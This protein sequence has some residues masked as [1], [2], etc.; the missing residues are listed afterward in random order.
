M[1]RDYKIVGS[2]KFRIIDTYLFKKQNVRVIDDMDKEC[3][4]LIHKSSWEMI[5]KKRDGV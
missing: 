3:F 4:D 1:K 2:G 5:F